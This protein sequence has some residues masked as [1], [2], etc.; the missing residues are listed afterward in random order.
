MPIRYEICFELSNP[1]PCKQ[2]IY[3]PALFLNKDIESL[4]VLRKWWRWKDGRTYSSQ[5]SLPEKILTIVPQSG[6]TNSRS[7]REVFEMVIR[8]EYLG[9]T[10]CRECASSWS[11][12]YLQNSH[13]SV[14]FKILLQSLVSYWITTSF[15]NSNTA[16]LVPYNFIE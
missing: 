8:Q 12:L 3:L 7:W 10:S 6:D 5:V 14:T 1:R 11:C 13:A 2:C 9:S 4:Q 15:V 16:P